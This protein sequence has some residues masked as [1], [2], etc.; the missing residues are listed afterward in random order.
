MIRR[1]RITFI[2][3]N[4][5]IVTVMLLVIF[6]MVFHFT[7][8]DMRMQSV[9]MMEM[10]AQEHQ[11]PAERPGEIP[12]R[13][14][15]PVFVVDITDDGL[16]YSVGGSFS[17]EKLVL[18]LVQA[19]ENQKE[20][21]GVLQNHQL[22]F[23]KL[24]TP[25]GGKIIFADISTELETTRGLLKTCCFIGAVSLLVFFG[26]SVALANWAV[27]PVETAWEQQRQFVADASHEL[28]TPLTVIM[29]NT[30]LL[31]NPDCSEME[32]EAF[33][34]GIRTV[35]R[36]MRGLVE[37]LL[38]LARVDNG[39]AKMEFEVLDFSELVQESVMLFEPVYF[40]KGLELQCQ[41]EASVAVRG[42]RTHLRQVV[43][44]LLDNGAKYS[45]DAGAVRI[46][47]RRQGN[48]CL[49]SVTS[50]GEAISKADLKN[51]F[52]RFY[53]ISQS[54]SRD[55]SYGLGLSIADSI[56]REHGGKIW[57][58][59]SGGHNTFHVQLGLTDPGRL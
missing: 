53:R 39:S 9:R 48:H 13:F 43:E 7:R 54:R 41:A 11:P 19:A 14:R 52:K 18:E 46:R 27:R 5:T 17:D 2:C 42:S 26:I 59:S 8:E 34:Q 22:R 49:L 33:L 57:A 29:T 1:L 47:L 35:S 45:S 38:E 30:E 21:E 10:A 4:M 44:I 32:R 16:R 20:T 51:I 36:Q 15:M 31:Q 23:R 6:G 24:T 50:P 58:E 3:I 55:G 28:K 12:D 56:L 37:S 40:E 25:K